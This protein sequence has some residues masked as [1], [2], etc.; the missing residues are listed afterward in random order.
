[1][2]SK[3]EDE[4]VPE[5]LKWCFHSEVLKVPGK[6]IVYQEEL[7]YIVEYVDVSHENCMASV[8]VFDV[9]CQETKMFT[10]QLRKSG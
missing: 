7:R 1:M 3:C 4:S 8:T 6:D 2:V 10:F 5:I 9:R